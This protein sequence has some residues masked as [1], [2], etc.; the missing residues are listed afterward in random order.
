MTVADPAT[1]ELVYTNAGHNPPLLM[2]AAGGFETLAG[3]GMI[4]GILPKAVYKESR[5]QHG[6]RRCSGAV[7]RRRHRSCQPRDEDFGEERLARVVAS[8]RDRPAAEIVDAVE[9]AVTEFSEGAPPADDV[10][11]VIARKT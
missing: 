7:Q 10:T 5:A 4:L 2:R 1:G 8:M 9:A 6:A 11:I 3:G